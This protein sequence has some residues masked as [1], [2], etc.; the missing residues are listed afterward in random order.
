M[1]I[2]LAL[3]G[4]PSHSLRFLPYY[5][6]SP[7]AKLSLT[8]HLNSGISG[9][10]TDNNTADYEQNRTTL[11]NGYENTSVAGLYLSFF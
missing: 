2:L 1:C 10:D 7:C 3:Q 6:V 8:S 4:N 11:T 5:V 9:Y